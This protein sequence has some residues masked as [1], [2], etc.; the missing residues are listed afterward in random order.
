MLVGGDLVGVAMNQDGPPRPPA[1]TIT[2]PV[3]DA[4]VPNHLTVGGSAEI[5]AAQQLWVLV[6]DEGAAP[7]YYLSTDA[8]I[9]V[10][11]SGLWESTVTLGKIPVRQAGRHLLIAIIVPDEFFH[12]DLEARPPQ[13]YSVRLP[14]IPERLN[15]SKRCGDRQGMLIRPDTRRPGP[16][17]GRFGRV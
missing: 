13:E 10:D 5:G 8:P 7:P 4:T 17:P 6:E 15:G 9:A 12:D 1:V 14:Q 11:N 16:S 2:S 3:N